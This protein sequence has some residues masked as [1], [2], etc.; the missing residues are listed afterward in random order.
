MNKVMKPREISFTEF[1]YENISLE[2]LKN[3]KIMF[4]RTVQIAKFPA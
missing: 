4:T 2:E 3:I 1:C